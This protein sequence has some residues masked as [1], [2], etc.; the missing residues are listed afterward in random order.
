MFR[1]ATLADIDRIEEIYNEIHSREEAGLSTIGWQRGV[2][3][4][5]QTA[6]NGVAERDMFVLGDGGRIVAAARINQLQ[7]PEYAL[8]HWRHDA[9]EE[10]I[11]VLHTLVVSPNCM[12]Q[13][14]GT[15]FVAFY[16][17]YALEHA[18]PFL[19]MDTNARNAAARALYKRLGYEEISIVPCTFNGINGVQLVCLEKKLE[20]Q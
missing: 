3:P 12:G 20:A 14:Y 2:Y 4:T 1:M 19:R 5:R 15:Q 10:Q 8:A 13:G 9:P 16:E 6:E 17:R 18:C 11:M 7:L